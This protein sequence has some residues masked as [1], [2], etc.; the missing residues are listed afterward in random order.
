MDVFMS[1]IV[2]TA[3]GTIRAQESLS[4]KHTANFASDC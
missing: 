1:R 3:A 2:P 4:T